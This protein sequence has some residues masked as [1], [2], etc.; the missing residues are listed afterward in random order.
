MLYDYWNSDL[1]SAKKGVPLNATV[2]PDPPASPSADALIDRLTAVLPK[3]NHLLKT[4]LAGIQG[5]DRVTLPQLRSL[6]EIAESDGGMLTSILARNLR[7]AAPTI[8]RVV[9]GLVERGLVERRPDPVD[10]RRLR[11][12]ILPPGEELLAAYESSLH[13]MLA[14]RLPA[15]SPAN[16][17]ALLHALD[18]LDLLLTDAPDD[19]STSAIG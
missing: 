17:T 13:I 1:T 7:S 4:V 19:E 10:R 15:I 2:S 3:Y 12:A 6:R 14:G 8:T 18:D 5:D 9:D 16:Q 11:L